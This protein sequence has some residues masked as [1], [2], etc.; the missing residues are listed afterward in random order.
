MTVFKQCY[1]PA[2]IHPAGWDNW[3]NPANE[4]TARYAEYRN[5]GP[6]TRIAERAAWSRQ[7]TDAAAKQLTVQRVF[8][9]WDPL[10]VLNQIQHIIAQ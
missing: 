5:E 3:R 6:G 8:G 10:M 9:D 4:K 1:L 2:V 7:L